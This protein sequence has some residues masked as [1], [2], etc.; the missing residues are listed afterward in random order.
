ML[1]SI[2][3]VAHAALHPPEQT[4][5]AAAAAAAALRAW[6]HAAAQS[7]VKGYRD[8]SAGLISVP[9]DAASLRA[10]LDLF[11]FEKALYE[12]RYEMDNR[13]D[14]ISIPLRGLIGLVA[15]E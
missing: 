2:S 10:L 3:Y 4:Q 8:A 5:E 11:T 13:P 6:E 1:R 7:L 9:A 12:L 14:W 15:H